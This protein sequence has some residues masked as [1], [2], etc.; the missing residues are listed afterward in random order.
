MQNHAPG[1]SADCH[2]RIFNGDGSLSLISPPFWPDVNPIENVR[3]EPKKIIQY[4]LHRV[5]HPQIGRLG[6]CATCLG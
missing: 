1:H 3:N 4:E 2:W 6:S 5:R